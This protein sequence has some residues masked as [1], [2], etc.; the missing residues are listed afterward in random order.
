MQQ[1]SDT[2][3]FNRADTAIRDESPNSCYDMGNEISKGDAVCFQGAALRLPAHSTLEVPSS[4]CREVPEEDMEWSPSLVTQLC[5][6]TP[7]SAQGMARK[8]KIEWKK[9][10]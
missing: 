7:E 9:G 1:L 3:Q 10:L 6:A 2:T 4:C 5:S 8:K